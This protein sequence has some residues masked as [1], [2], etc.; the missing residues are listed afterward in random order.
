MIEYISGKVVEVEE[1]ALVLDIA[2]IAVRM[3]M[4][5]ALTMQVGKGVTVYTYMYWNAEQGPSLFCFKTTVER[6]LFLSLISCSGIGPKIAIAILS[7]FTP[8]LLVQAITENNIKALSAVPGIGAKKAEQLI[9]QVRHKLPPILAYT[10]DESHLRQIA[11]VLTS[12]HYSRP[13]IT[14]ALQHVQQ[15]SQAIP[16]DQLLRKAL[17]FLVR[18]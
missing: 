18:Q 3:A 4:P 17:A 14:R 13:E 2:G 8:S 6:S 11:D 16:F 15:D 1:A 9:V 10:A 7:Q 5:H 12:L